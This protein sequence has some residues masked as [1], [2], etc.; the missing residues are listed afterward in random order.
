MS[1]L[2]TLSSE[3]AKLVYLYLTERGEAT[4]DEL[5]AALDEQLLTLLPVLRTLERE[6]LVAKRGGRYAPT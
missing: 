1:S 4:A 5:A 2:R 3:T 6:G